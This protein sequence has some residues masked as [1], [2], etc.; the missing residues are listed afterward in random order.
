MNESILGF[1][2]TVLSQIFIGLVLGFCWNN[3]MTELG[4]HSLSP[5]AALSAWFGFLTAFFVLAFIIANMFKSTMLQGVVE[6]EPKRN[7]ETKENSE[8]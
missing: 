4:F 8:D 7:T 6:V 3:S 5:F 2:G 1:I